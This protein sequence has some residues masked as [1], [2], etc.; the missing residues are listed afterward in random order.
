M[1]AKS[2]VKNNICKNFNSFELLLE[3]AK[4]QT[5]INEAIALYREAANFAWKNDCGI[6]SSS[7]LEAGLHDCAKLFAVDADCADAEK[8]PLTVSIATSVHSA[9]GHTRLLLRWLSLDKQSKHRLI[10]TEQGSFPLPEQLLSLVEAGLVELC[11]LKAASWSERV[12]ELCALLKGASRA[13]FHTHPYDVLPVIALSAMGGR[14]PAIFVD[15][16]SHVFWVGASVANIVMCLLDCNVDIAVNQRLIGKQHIRR[17]PMPLNFSLIDKHIGNTIDR[18]LLGIPADAIVLLTSGWPYKFRPIDGLSLQDII[19]NTVVNN[20]NVHL[21]AIGPDAQE[22]DWQALSLA[23]KNRVHLLGLRDE[24]FFTS[25]L[26]TADIYLDAYPFSSGTA[27]IEAAS[28]KLPLIKFSTEDARACGFSIHIDSLD[29][30]QYEFSDV[31]SYNNFLLKLIVDKGFRAQQGAAANEMVRQAHAEELIVSCIESA[32]RDAKNVG[33]VSFETLA[34]TQQVGVLNELN[35]KLGQNGDDKRQAQTGDTNLNAV[36]AIAFHLPQFH[37][38]P[39]NDAWWGKG[40]TEWSNVREGKPL[41]DGHYQPHVPAGNNYYDL[42]DVGILNAQAQLARQYGIEGFCFY[43]YWFDG[44]R[45]LEK[46]VDQLILHPEIN[47]PFCLCWANENWT[48]RWDGGEYEILIKQSYAPDS[49]Q[50]FARDL[51]PYLRDARYIRVNGKPLILI[52]RADIIPDLFETVAAWRSIWRREGMGE[53]YLICVESF[54]TRIPSNYGF[55]AA[56]EFFPHQVEF[57]QLLPSMRPFHPNDPQAKIADYNK[58]AAVAEARPNPGY[59][60]FRGIIPSWD[61]SSRRRKGGASLFIDATPER[62]EA[63]LKNTVR[64]TLIEQDGDERLVFINAWNE[65][66]EGCHLEP[67]DRYGHAWLE[68]TMRAQH[69]A[70]DVDVHFERHIRPYQQWLDERQSQIEAATQCISGK[71]HLPI[72]FTVII[73]ATACSAEQLVET[74][75]SFS[76]Q[77]YR[78]IGLFVVAPLAAPANI[79]K[80]VLWLQAETFPEILLDELTRH[81]PD[82]WF[83]LIRAGD[84]AAGG[85]F[86]LLATRLSGEQSGV[87]LVYA[88]EDILD[89]KYGPSNPVF[90]PDFDLDYLRSF[91]YT[92]RFISFRGREYLELGGFDWSAG[93]AKF[94]DYVLRFSERYEIAAVYHLPSIL[95][96]AGAQCEIDV[97]AQYGHSLAAHLQR[98][99]LQAVV[100]PGLFPGSFRVRYE[101]DSK[102]LVSIIIPTKNQLP[103]L[104]R[105]VESLLEKT[106]YPNC[107]I[108]L[109]DNQSS[110]A[111]AVE[112]LE[113]LAGLN[114]QNLRV[115]TYPFEFNFA[116]MNNLVAREARGEYLVLLNNDTA[117]VKNDWLDAMLNHA[118][119]PEVGI[120]GAKLLYPDGRV[121]HAGV[122][123][124]LRGPA[125][126]PF[127]GEA[128]D[129][130][131]YCGRLLVDQQYSAVTAACMMVR[132]SVYESVGG[133]DADVFR[134]SYNDVDLCLK[135][136]EAG[137]RIVWTP[138]AVVMHEGSVSQREVDQSTLEAKKQRFESE[139]YA[140]YRKWLPALI[141]DPAYNPNLGLTNQGFE[142][143]TDPIFCPDIGSGLP[144][145]LAHNADS[146][147]SGS[148][149]VIEPL[150]AMI[151]AG[152]VKGQCREYFFDPI[153]VAKAA[154]EVVVFQRQFNNEQLRHIRNYH[155][156]SGAK[157]IYDIDDYLPNLPASSVHKTNFPKD[158]LQRLKLAAS[159]CDRVTVSTEFLK[160]ALGDFHPDVV[161]QPNYLP[162]TLWRDAPLRAAPDLKSRPRVG[163]AGGLSHTGDL[164]LIVDV[165]KALANRVD[166]VFFGMV[167]EGVEN[168]IAEFHPGVNIQDYPLRLAGL[169]LD[170]A[171]AP[172]DH[173]LFNKCKSNLRLLEYGICGYPVIASDEEPYRCNLPVTLVKNRF[174]D[175]VAAIDEKLGDRQALW[176]EG[177]ALQAAVRERW[178]LTDTNLERWRA[179]WMVPAPV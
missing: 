86:S 110:D 44:K 7:Q 64:Q 12:Q 147:G 159:F 65:W 123:L 175:W 176:L 90:R 73:D 146:H 26:H 15:H 177:L 5:D 41:F 106:A 117:I 96:H 102:P 154:A 164:R 62:Y 2:I 43:Y 89:A 66:G 74:L 57:A 165:V 71:S 171:L 91:P 30:L 8:S 139:Q 81:A 80:S 131:G 28:A 67:D 100:E 40:F 127:G 148:Y 88:D 54:T 157:L 4:K 126:H 138:Y 132:K 45:L 172:L 36:R 107:E 178:M 173:N 116:D 85:G 29:E 75:K 121:Q 11:V 38:I 161:V 48:R 49:H 60:R 137:Y 83:C 119:R 84:L 18:N 53:V 92:G 32:Y 122:I 17:M 115:F 149:R 142:L 111:D 94:Y 143:E 136:R 133:M 24:S 99:R 134:V 160:E 31:K 162:L 72:S 103:M 156:F 179:A 141:A 129:S 150:Q 151:N 21:V 16:A 124:G 98:C 56:C 163:W 79:G 77:N 174:K 170:L 104:Q 23:A 114:Q 33:V 68:A 155:E 13:V 109:V 19:F 37:S 135:V 144:K 128:M 140:M 3:S 27:L 47:L 76:E 169:N 97:E 168:Y 55:D 158:T 69:S 61:N 42:S 1:V 108:L 25:M 125:D 118:Q 153:H 120:V 9:G 78:Q 39:E 6:Y 130:P 58:L 50:R 101:H 10:L 70:R 20:D 52:Y 51:I 35:F 34:K 95:F 46:P 93:S 152:Y 113:G 59:K 112:Y 82:S 87:G 145:V 63:W 22:K 167:P 105:C 166:W 14:I